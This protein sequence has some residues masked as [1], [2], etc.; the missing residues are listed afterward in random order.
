MVAM[1][2]LPLV[3]STSNPIQWIALSS[4]Y[5]NPA[6]EQALATFC[7]L[8][9]PVLIAA[10][11]TLLKL[12]ACPLTTLVNR[13]EQN[14]K[15]AYDQFQELRQ[16]GQTTDQILKKDPSLF[17]KLTTRTIYTERTV[18]ASYTAGYQKEGML[19]IDLLACMESCALLKQKL[20]E[21]DFLDQ[22]EH[23]QTLA[24][25][26]G[27]KNPK[28][29]LAALQELDHPDLKSLFARKNPLHIFRQDY[30]QQKAEHEFWSFIE[31]YKAFPAIQSL[32]FTT[33]IEFPKGL[34][35]A[36]SLNTSPL[37]LSRLFQKVDRPAFSA[38]CIAS[39]LINPTDGKGDNYF[40]EIQ[41]KAGKI[42]KLTLLAIDNDQALEPA[43]VK[44][45]AGKTRLRLKCLPLVL[46]PMQL[47]ID[48]QIKA[49]LLKHT[50]QELIIDW[51]LTLHT[52]HVAYQQS[53]DEQVLCT[54]DLLNPF[55][56][57]KL[58]I[59]LKLPKGHTLYPTWLSSPSYKKCSRE[60]PPINS[61]FEL[62]EPDAFA[63]Y[64]TLKEQVKSPIDLSLALH[65][66]TFVPKGKA[67]I[68]QA[69]PKPP[70]IAWDLE[71][72]QFV[73][74]LAHRNPAFR[75]PVSSTS[76]S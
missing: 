4:D 55:G 73:R 46:S 9:S 31:L 29:L 68:G 45:G 28:I 7:N 32:P 40:V 72:K 27:S 34:R 60:T 51:L 76:I 24:H 63:A 62:L 8:L 1:L 75:Y 52:Q 5:L 36:K 47:P 17:A 13:R 22:W 67:S 33:L 71:A 30:L 61:S 54:A 39:L 26:T 69:S 37:E 20:G 16:S 65:R 11:A 57:S 48:P 58:D 43:L 59:P 38:L 25:T 64:E 35:I 56:E 23:L 6:Q 44:E 70:Q 42:D 66:E 14:D 49:H 15:A 18:Q 41:R 50:A 74:T 3:A 19:L 2:S 21:E 53:Y 12:R 10:P